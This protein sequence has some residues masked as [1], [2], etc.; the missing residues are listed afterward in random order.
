MQ[1][2][3][4]VALWIVVAAAIIAVLKASGDACRRSR[5]AGKPATFTQDLCNYGTSFAA[6][7]LGI[8]AVL[9]AVAAVWRR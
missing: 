5:V 6:V 4:A 3:V 7:A 1:K 8:A 2:F 9:G